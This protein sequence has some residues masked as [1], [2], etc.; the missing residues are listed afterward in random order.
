MVVTDDD[1]Y[2]V[3]SEIT[4]IPLNRLN[5]NQKQQLL[6]LDEKLEGSVIGQEEAIEK[7]SKSIRRNS[8]GI[9]EENKPIGSFIFLGPTGVG[10]THLAKKL[11][12]EVFGSE[13]NIIRVDMSEFQEKHS[14]SRLI[15]S[16]PGYVGYNEGG[17]LTEK[18]RNNPYSL[19][20]FDEIEKSHRD[21]FN[22]MLQI[23]DDG[24]ITDASGRKI[25]FKNTDLIKQA[26]VEENA[27]SI[28]KLKGDTAVSKLGLFQFN[29]YVE[30]LMVH[31]TREELESIAIVADM[32]DITGMEKNMTKTQLATHIAEEKSLIELQKQKLGPY[33]KEKNQQTQVYNLQK[34]DLVQIYSKE[35]IKK[36]FS[37]F[38]YRILGSKYAGKVKRKVF[39]DY[40]KTKTLSA[41]KIPTM[42]TAFDLEKRRVKM[43][44]SWTEGYLPARR[45][46]AAT[47][48]A[49]TYFPAESIEGQWY[50]DGAVSTNNP[51]L[52]PY[53][54]AKKLWPNEEIKV[55][56]VG[57]GYNS[58][59]FLCERN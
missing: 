57:T 15:G 37:P 34:D 47:S 58:R 17:Q 42:I 10:K 59:R 19:V 29:Q 7:V 35:N 51:V 8:V 27:D 50:I 43:F 33:L 3:V 46:A 18:V 28:M 53:A 16:P 48:A 45:V 5:T 13:E 44:K 31:Y 41:S 2:S 12:K 9:K 39:E 4:K 49:P 36:I 26:M 55:L 14:L 56:S 1:V 32:F 54:E 22:V 24:F 25:N 23:L 38:R 40:F 30:D 52:I 21:I 11:A 6:D 20:L